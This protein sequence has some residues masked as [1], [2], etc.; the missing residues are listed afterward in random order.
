M[1]HKIYFL[2]YMNSLFNFDTNKI[3]KID[4]I[5]ISEIEIANYDYYDCYICAGYDNDNN[6]T[7]E[8]NNIFNIKDAFVFDK[9]YQYKQTSLSFHSF[10]Y[11]YILC[12]YQW[13]MRNDI[14]NY[15]YNMNIT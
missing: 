9:N 4:K 6:F 3:D 11:F 2:I 1:N 14:N 10:A 15:K 5:K 12:L 7:N 13:L 8:I